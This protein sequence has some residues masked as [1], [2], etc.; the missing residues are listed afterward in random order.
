MRGAVRRTGRMLATRRGVAAVFALAVAGAFSSTAA[1]EPRTASPATAADQCSGPCPA[2]V[3]SKG[4]G[5]GQ[6]VAV[7]FEG[8]TSSTVPC[9]LPSRGSCTF[10]ISDTAT[11]AELRAF[12]GANTEFRG[13][14]QCAAARGNVCPVVP[15]SNVVVCAIFGAPGETIPESSCPPPA[16][17]LFKKGDGSGTVTLQGA[18]GTDSCGV[19]C[20]SLVSKVFSPNE[21]VTLT[22]SAAA[23]STFVDWEG[24]PA[25]VGSSCTFPLTTA[26]LI[27]AVF[28]KVG[29]TRPSDPSCPYYPT[30]PKQEPSGPPKLGSKCT[31]IGSPGGDV[32]HGTARDDVICGR[33]GND[34]IHGR[35]GNDL[36]VGGRGN[37]RL[38]GGPGKDLLVGGAGRDLLNG[39]GGADTLLGGGG[40]DTI[41]A[42]DGVRD[43]V[44]GGRGGD[45]ARVD[46]ADRLRSIE[47]RF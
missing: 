8:G 12:P 9:N 34:V 28:V 4:N 7:T 24:C 5:S 47:R 16:V 46:R 13:W 33:G 44:N 42:R 40:A 31:I 38:Y 11:S 37:D 14:D 18:S 10:D 19:S 1:A 20:K 6:I 27:C 39:G 2:V 30:P 43:V 32:I 29:S 22:A 15:G 3:F 41:Y 25:R 17:L 35:G 26:T 23:D 45:R 21:T 36:L